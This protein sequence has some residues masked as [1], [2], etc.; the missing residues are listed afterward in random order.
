[1]SPPT[2]GV[3]IPIGI[4]VDPDVL[5]D[6]HT[7]TAG[8]LQV[9]MAHVAESAPELARQISAALE[10]PVVSERSQWET[11]VEAWNSCPTG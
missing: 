6:W 11:T 9:R 4:D 1:M 2:I 7:I 5:V 10:A 8:G 3:E